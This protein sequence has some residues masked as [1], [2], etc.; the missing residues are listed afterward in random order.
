MSPDRKSDGPNSPDRATRPERTTPARVLLMALSTA[1]V[2]A[3][4]GRL[5]DL[6]H[7]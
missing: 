7:S 1:V 4:V 6:L 2:R 3:V 5:L